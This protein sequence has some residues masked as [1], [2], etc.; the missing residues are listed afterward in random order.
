MNTTRLR[1]LAGACAAG[2]ATA[3]PAQA[4]NGRNVEYFGSVEGS[5]LFS[6][7]SDFASGYQYGTDPF[8]QGETDLGWGVRAE[9]GMRVGAWVFSIGGTW[10]HAQ[11]DDK[12]VQSGTG[13]TYFYDDT[14]RYLAVDFMVGQ[15]F[16]L[17]WATLRPMA[18]LRIAS[19]EFQTTTDNPYNNGN[20]FC[21]YNQKSETWAF[22]PR[23]GASANVPLGGGFSIDASA[24]GFVLFGNQ[25]RNDAYNCNGTGTTYADDNGKTL[26]GG[27]GE[28]GVT[29]GFDLTNLTRGAIT[30]GYRVDYVHD[31]IQGEQTL[32]DANLANPPFRDGEPEDYLT[33]GVFVKFSV[34]F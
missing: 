6:E 25:A 12:S 29:Y 32:Y 3:A 11:R 22:G 24:Y 31:A 33:H 27:D 13:D 1:L 34:D 21:Y 8:R 2:L 26:W 4:D 19:I 20:S 5:F 17:G 15:E 7:I 14:S 10:Q 28:L 16:G 23:I 30:V 9:A 18:G